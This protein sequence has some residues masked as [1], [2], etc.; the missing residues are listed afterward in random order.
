MWSLLS[1]GQQLTVIVA[2][3]VIVVL[4]LEAAWTKFAGETPNPLKLVSLVVSIIGVVLVGLAEFLWRRLWRWFPALGAKAFP[5][6]NGNWT[7]ILSSTWIDP[8]TGAVPPPIQTSVMIRQS[9]FSTSVSLQTG[10]LASHSTRCFLE[11]FPETRRFR[12]WYS[13][14]NDPQAR[15]RCRSSP[16]EGVAFLELDYETDLNRLTG[17]YYTAR[18]TTGDLDLRRENSKQER[19]P[20]AGD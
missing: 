1:R 3:T 5:D 16:H 14:N 15:V 2:A 4:G 8:A 6:L 12:I 13:Y 7:G 10:E 9:L 11:R 20:L 17:R 18:K 19:R